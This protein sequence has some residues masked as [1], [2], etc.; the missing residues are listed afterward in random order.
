MK[1]Q[2]VI[3]PLLVVAM[4]SGFYCESASAGLGRMAGNE[5]PGECHEHESGEMGGRFLTRMAKELGLS[6]EQKEQARKIFAAERETVGPLLKKMDEAKGRVHEAADGAKFDEPAVRAA[7]AG[8]NELRTELAVARARTR[9]SINA[10]LTPEQ[11]EAA[12]R[13]APPPRPR[14]GRGALP[15]DEL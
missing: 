10:I 5:S 6:P 2:T 3:G 9:S 12:K 14:P 13:L 7:V 11:R 4:A 1:R 8:E 15:P